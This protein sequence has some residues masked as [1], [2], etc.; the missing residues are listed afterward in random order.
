[1]Q[2]PHAKAEPTILYFGTPVVLISTTNEDGSANIAPMS[3]A[4]WLGWRCMLHA[5]TGVKLLPLTIGERT[6]IFSW[7]TSL[8]NNTLTKPLEREAISYA[9]F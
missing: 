2:R 7:R 6:A 1:M 9:C 5:R 3:C 4:F 8:R